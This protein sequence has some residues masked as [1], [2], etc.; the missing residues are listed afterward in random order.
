M[1][2]EEWNK[3]KTL[4]TLIDIDWVEDNPDTAYELLNT[5]YDYC[6]ELDSMIDAYHQLV[7]DLNKENKKLYKNI[8]Q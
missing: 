1:K 7:V 6:K 2:Q 4:M 5:I 8:K 3:I